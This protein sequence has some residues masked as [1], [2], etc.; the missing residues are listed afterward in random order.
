M[1]LLTACCRYISANS[2]Y[3][4][5]ILQ[6]ESHPNV[7]NQ[8]PTKGSSGSKEGL[9]VYGLFH[10]LANTP[11]GKYLL[12][13]QFLRPNVD[14]DVINQRLDTLSTLLSPTNASPFSEITKGLA[15]IVNV[16]VLMIKMR[17]GVAGGSS[18]AAGLARNIWLGLQKVERCYMLK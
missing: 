6:S 17:A 5:Q 14:I 10:H 2:L 8:G 13:Q 4:L 12:R 15:S 18:K 16:R 11:Q 7:H 3:A 9:S 1:A